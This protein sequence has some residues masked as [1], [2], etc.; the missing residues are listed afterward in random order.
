MKE[1][2][3]FVSQNFLTNSLKNSLAVSFSLLICLLSE[4][5]LQFSVSK[6]NKCL[7]Y[8]HNKPAGCFIF[9]TCSTFW[10]FMHHYTTSKISASPLPC[11]FLK[12]AYEN[13]SYLSPRVT[14][15]KFTISGLKIIAD[16]E[17]HWT[18]PC[19]LLLHSFHIKRWSFFNYLH[20]EESILNYS[21]REQ[22][23]IRLK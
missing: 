10:C 21:E 9:L 16:K 15:Y 13:L 12:L 2:K 17:Q 18:L 4:S 23:K 20:K 1:K 11:T 3:K 14:I 19:S 8:K 5:T 7:V 6:F 22:L